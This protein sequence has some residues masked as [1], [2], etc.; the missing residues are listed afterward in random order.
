MSGEP[1]WINEERNTFK[2]HDRDG[3]NVLDN[4]EIKEW[5]LPND[6]DHVAEE[7]HHLIKESDK[8]SDHM[9]TKEE[10]IA[11]YKLFVGSSVTNFG[12]DMYTKSHDE[13]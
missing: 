7:A 6:I 1:R 13:L 11:K 2:I 3:D 12:A 5:I 4:E 10:I 8:N 9:L